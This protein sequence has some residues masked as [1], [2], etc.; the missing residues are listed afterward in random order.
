MCGCEWHG[1]LY[2]ESVGMMCVDVNG[3]GVCRYDVWM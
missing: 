3:M 1:D 2:G